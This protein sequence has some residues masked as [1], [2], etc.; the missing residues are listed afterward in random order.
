MTLYYE[1]NREGTR[2]LRVPMTEEAFLRAKENPDRWFLD[3]GN[4]V[5]EVTKQEYD[6]YYKTRERSKYIRRNM[7]GRLDEQSTMDTG[8]RTFHK[9]YLLLSSNSSLYDYYI[10]QSVVCPLPKDAIS[11]KSDIIYPCSERYIPTLP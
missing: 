4:C 9:R 3:F 11:K 10:I 7:E 5:L 1:Y 6:K 2:P 8:I